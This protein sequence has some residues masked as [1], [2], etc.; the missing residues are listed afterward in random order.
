MEHGNTTPSFDQAEL[1]DRV[2]GDMEF[3]QES[4]EMLQEDSVSLLDE[5]RFAVGA[6]DAPAL[7]KPAHALKGMLSNFCS[8]MAEACAREVEV[9]AREGRLDYIN[10]LVAVIVATSSI[11]CINNIAAKVKALGL[12]SALGMVPLVTGAA[13]LIDG[14]LFV[15]DV[16]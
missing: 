2:D 5:I 12:R 16:R 1:L 7:V 14:A 11:P 4:V 9:K 3:L 8:T 15:K 13:V 10:A 6:S